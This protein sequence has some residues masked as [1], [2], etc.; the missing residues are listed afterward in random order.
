MEFLF[1]YNQQHPCFL[2]SILFTILKC[3]PPFFFRKETIFNHL[4]TLVTD[5]ND[6][7][8]VGDLGFEQPVR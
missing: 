2:V 5:I 8:G 3:I 6:F 1:T 4:W 7:V